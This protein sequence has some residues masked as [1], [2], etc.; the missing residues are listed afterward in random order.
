MD[1]E[2]PVDAR[3]VRRNLATVET[4][5][6]QVRAELSR[7][8]RPWWFL[9]GCA[10][11]V[12]AAVASTSLP[13]PEAGA[14]MTLIVAGMAGLAVIER[15]VVRLMPHWRRFTAAS[16]GVV[17]GLCGTV[18]TVAVGSRVLFDTIG[19]PAASVVSGGAVALTVAALARPSLRWLGAGLRP[20]DR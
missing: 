20:D 15:K 1:T 3:E 11:T 19:V 2:R 17:L 9:A 18:V 13:R 12:G 6:R 4:A 10:V 7:G 16:A 14:A 5:R 8:R